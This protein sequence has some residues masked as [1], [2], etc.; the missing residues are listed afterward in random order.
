MCSSCWF[1]QSGKS[2][3]QAIHRKINAQFLI[4][5][6]IL[7]N[8]LGYETYDI[9]AALYRYKDHEAEERDNKVK[10]ESKEVKEKQKAE[11][12]KRREEAKVE[13][14]LQAERDRKQRLEA[15]ENLRQMKVME[16]VASIT[17]LHTK[18]EAA[19]D[20]LR[21]QQVPDV[22]LTSTSNSSGSSYSFVATPRVPVPCKPKIVIEIDHS[23]DDDAMHRPHQHQASNKSVGKSSPTRV[24]DFKFSD[25]EVE[26]K[27]S[28]SGDKFSDA[29]ES[30]GDSP[31]KWDACGGYIYE[32]ADTNHLQPFHCPIGHNPVVHAWVLKCCGQTLCKGCYLECKERGFY[33]CPL[34]NSEEDKFTL[35]HMA[36]T[37]LTSFLDELR[38]ICSRCSDAFPRHLLR[39][40][41]ER[42]CPQASNNASAP[43][44]VSTWQCA[45]CT[46]ENVGPSTTKC[47]MCGK[48]K[49]SKRPF[50]E[51]SSS[52]AT[53]SASIAKRSKV[54]IPPPQSSPA[55][56]ATPEDKVIRSG[57]PTSVGPV[58]PAAT[59][60]IVHS[61]AV[62]SDDNGGKLRMQ[63]LP[64]SAIV[65][66]TISPSRGLLSSLPVKSSMPA[67]L[68]RHV[69]HWNS[70]FN[71]E[72]AKGDNDQDM[73][74]Y[75]NP[76]EDADDDKK[77]SFPVYED[78]DEDAATDENPAPILLC[79]GADE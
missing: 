69:L 77:Y 20:A 53:T 16:R 22:R 15:K 62:F 25:D 40:H 27:V 72:T 29:G 55:D 39:R 60:S 13:K 21:R 24:L 34:C 14:I 64:L 43:R 30:D 58:T 66:G 63:R 8:C 48:H 32:K 74:V 33:A 1:T 50:T 70:L 17:P 31:I 2:P 51:V 11:A 71:A 18:L 35:S 52:S 19:K 46:F 38:C 76:K 45:V 49:G 54:I 79:E 65:N 57:E 67:P 59:S 23:S 5:V 47:E 68:P 73:T 3:L 9:Y 42:C 44:A 10:R 61:T 7:I 75:E 26:P 37:M 56:D 28:D 12:K 4:F 41:Y 36:S 78:G 6:V